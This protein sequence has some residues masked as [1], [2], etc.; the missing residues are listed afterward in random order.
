MH[1]FRM[2]HPLVNQQNFNLVS[3]LSSCFNEFRKLRWEITASGTRTKITRI[4]DIQLNPSIFIK[5]TKVLFSV[6]TSNE[7]TGSFFD[8]WARHCNDKLK[9]PI[10]LM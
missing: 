6:V 9:E 10:L 5:L 4:N 7:T 3:I 2:Q 1:G 8:T